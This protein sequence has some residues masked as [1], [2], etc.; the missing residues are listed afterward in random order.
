MEKSAYEKISQVLNRRI[1][2]NIKS[3]LA[4]RGLSQAEFC[5]QMDTQKVSVTRSYFNR[6]INHPENTPMPVTLAASCCDFFGITIDDLL[7]E[8]FD[9]NEYAFNDTP[10]HKKY[11]D[12]ENLLK[13]SNSASTRTQENSSKKRFSIEAIKDINIQNLIID[14]QNSR[15]SGY[16]QNYHCYYYPT[17]SSEDCII[18]GILSLQP[19]NGCCKAIL[20]ID[21][22]TTSASGEKNYKNYE[23]FAAIAPLVNSMNCVMY[24]DSIGEFCFLMF[25][26]FKLNFGNQDCRLAEVLSTSAATENRRPTI[27]RMLLSR[28]EIKNEDLELVAPALLLNYSKILVS[29]DNL[30]NISN[31]SDSYNLIVNLLLENNESQSMI[32]LD[33]DNIVSTANK[34]LSKSETYELLMRLRAVSYANR[35]NKIGQKSDDAVR[36]I[37][38]SKNYYKK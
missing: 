30:H 2:E 14:P 1:C 3:L 19:D 23:G 32:L 33:E 34:Y 26:Y 16:L 37:L 36:K 24:G 22:N 17:H 11:L 31:L 4:A 8:N 28:E 18:K 25:R 10:E 21:T 15:F 27:L 29:E 35:Y 9:A 6:I 38:I 12:I 20:R 5:K 13:A 7:S